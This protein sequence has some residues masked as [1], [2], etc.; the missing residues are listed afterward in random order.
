MPGDPVRAALGPDGTRRSSSRPWREALG[1][2]LPLWQQYLN[3]LQGLFTGDLG[4]SIVLAAAGGRDHR[5][6]PARDGSPRPPRLPR[7]RRSSPSRSASPSPSRPTA[8]AA[9]VSSSA[10]RR[11]RLR[12]GDPRLPAR[13]RPRLRLRR[14]SSAGCRSPAASGPES[15]ILP[16]IA[17]AV[18]PAAVLARIVR[19]EM[20]SVLD[21]DYVRTARAKRLPR[22]RIYLS[23]A[24][25]NA[26]TAT[27][28]LAGLILSSL[29]IGT[30]LVESVFAWPGSARRSSAPSRSKDYPLVQAHRARLRSAG[31]HHQ[32]DRRLGP[33]GARPPHDGGGQ[34]MRALARILRTPLGIAAVMLLALV[35]L[36]AIFAPIIWGDAGGCRRHRQPARRPVGRAPDR[37]R[38]PRPRPAAARARRHPP[39]ARARPARDVRERH[40]RADPRHGALPARAPRARR[41]RGSSASRSPSPD[42]CSP[43]SSR[44]SSAPAGSARCSRSASPARRA[45][46]ASARRSSRAS[47]ERDF[48]AA[49]RIGGIGRFRVL[50]RHIL[51]NIGEPLIVNATIGAGGALLAFAGLSFIG[52]GVQ[53]PEYDWGRL[54]MEGLPGIYINPLAAI[55]PGIAV[56]IAGLA[57]NL[58]GEAA[59]R[60]LGI[61]SAGV[62]AKIEKRRPDADAAPH[63]RCRRRD[64]VVLEVVTCASRFPGAAGP[65][66]ARARRDASRSAAARPSAS[67]ASRDRASRSP[68]SSIAQLVA[69]ARRRRRR[70]PALPRRGPAAH[71]DPE[72][73][74]SLLGTSLAMVFQ[75]PMTSFNPT[76]RMGAQLAEVATEHQGMSRRE[77]HGRRPST[78]STR[79]GS[80][81]PSTARRSTR[82]SSRAACASAP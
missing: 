45:S 5:A 33:R 13:R 18:G 54:M 9:A 57:F 78:A 43:S 81:T 66:P 6:A 8:V 27:L 58:V 56:V 36:T 79:C 82:T 48:V 65:D 12:L 26:V 22:W 75:D 44:S 62:A 52:I 2:N 39:L 61:E 47:T 3:Y 17:L 49:A 23:H 80:P 69:G 1:L 4:T 41:S 34:L 64:D 25:P 28:T 21:A 38:P 11:Q 50:T 42:C 30:V 70:P 14:L 60:A 46:P 15:Y 20:L 40:R 72:R 37:H 10:S 19:V 76:K 32:H 67:S 35:V 29:V 53:P 68:R 51:P 16:V 7:R 77:A 31:A 63:R 74:R 71:G 24:L 59:A 55:A 73:Q